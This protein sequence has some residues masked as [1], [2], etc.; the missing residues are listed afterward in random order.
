MCLGNHLISHG[1]SYD[2]LSQ[3]GWQQ[4]QTLH[5]NTHNP[6]PKAKPKP[7]PQP[8]YA[9]TPDSVIDT[10]LRSVDL[11][12]SGIFLDLG[13]GDGRVVLAAAK[14]FGCKCVGVE[15]DPARI[16]QSRKLAQQAGAAIAGRV[17]FYQADVCNVD[18]SKVDVVY[19]YLEAETLEKLLPRFR[20]MKPS[21][22]LI[23]YQH[24]IPRLVLQRYDDEFKL[25][26]WKN[27]ARS[28][29]SLGS[30]LYL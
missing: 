20:A 12:P 7:K 25:F 16:V 18:L 5:D 6:L 23:S 13:S 26:F 14:R 30:S 11:S 9:P 24:Q 17:T 4:W 22:V 15:S 21:A 29:F 2:Y 10:M 1:Y 27:V 3:I 8:I 28:M 19:C